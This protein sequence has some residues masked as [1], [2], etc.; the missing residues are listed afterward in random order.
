MFRLRKLPMKT[1]KVVYSS[2]KFNNIVPPS[3]FFSPE[4]G[5]DPLVRKGLAGKVVIPGVPVE[6]I[7]LKK[8]DMRQHV[9]ENHHVQPVRIIVVVKRNGGPGVDDCFIGI[10][11]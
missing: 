3:P 2:C 1:D 8:V 10:C 5:D 7:A 6:E 11:G 4:F 9:V